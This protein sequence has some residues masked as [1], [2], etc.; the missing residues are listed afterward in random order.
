MTNDLNVNEAKPRNTP[1]FSFFSR[2]LLD[3]I[4]EM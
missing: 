3:N 1:P 4:S 2:V